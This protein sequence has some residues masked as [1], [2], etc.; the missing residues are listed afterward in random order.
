MCQ[1]TPI[2]QKCSD[3]LHN[4]FCERKLGMSLYFLLENKFSWIL[5]CE[6]AFPLRL[7]KNRAVRVFLGQRVAWEIVTVHFRAK[8]RRYLHDLSRSWF[9]SEFP[10]CLDQ[11]ALEKIR[12][13]LKFK[14]ILITKKEQTSKAI[15]VRLYL[16]VSEMDSREFE[17]L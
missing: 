10:W 7:L 11:M 6:I 5:I 12:D 3:R 9:C 14:Q 16:P 2:I 1:S 13:R 15:F 17:S 4:C 8:E